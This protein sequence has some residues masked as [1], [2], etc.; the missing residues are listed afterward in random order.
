M[1]YIYFLTLILFLPSFSFAFSLNEATGDV[2]ISPTEYAG[3]LTFCF[4]PPNPPTFA[5]PTI[6]TDVNTNGG[7]NPPTFYSIEIPSAGTYSFPY[8]TGDVVNDVYADCQGHFGADL[9]PAGTC[10]MG[11][12]NNGSTDLFIFP[13][14]APPSALAFGTSTAPAIMG[15]AISS[16]AGIM[17]KGAVSILGVLSALLGLGWGVSKFTRFI[18]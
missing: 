5:N 1:K 10:F 6:N 17:G 3:I 18:G 9:F 14:I 16:T 8:Q 12:C 15:S 7:T 4:D 13:F 11:D 2:T